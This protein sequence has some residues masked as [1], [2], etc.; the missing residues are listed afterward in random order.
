MKVDDRVHMHN[1]GTIS[2]HN[3]KVEKRSKSRKEHRSGSEESFSR[4]ASVSNVHYGTGIKTESKK[5]K[6]VSS[7]TA[8][9][10]LIENTIHDT[11]S[12]KDGNSH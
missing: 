2:G 3:S 4:V 10:P 12:F 5:A 7:F 1:T 8:Q 11:Q 9:A 6:I